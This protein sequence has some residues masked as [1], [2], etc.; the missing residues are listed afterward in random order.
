MSRALVLNASY[1]PLSV[2]AP[3]RALVLVLAKKAETL[4]E[5]AD[6]FHSEHLDLAVP[7]V[8][9]LMYFVKVPFFRSGG[10]SRRGVFA[11]DEYRCQYC[12]CHADSID[13]VHPKS[14]GGTHSWE[15]VVAACRRCNIAKRDRLL[16][17]THMRLLRPPAAPP[18]SA[19]VA[20]AVG[21]VPKDWLPYLGSAPE[22][23][24]QT[25]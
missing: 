15:N 1:E 18:R 7:S 10:L 9:R 20:S 23:V 12:G 4:L 2:V 19:W 6:R 24:A 5:S 3:R 25:A 22:S 17:E 11:R 8:V 13:H 16:S 21:Y 14:R